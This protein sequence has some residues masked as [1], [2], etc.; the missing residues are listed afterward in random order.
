MDGQYGDTFRVRCGPVARATDFRLG[1]TGFEYC[2][3]MSNPDK[4]IYA[5]FS[6]SFGCMNDYLSVDIYVQI[7]FAH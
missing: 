5:T 6:M 3:E 2:G 7:V 1:E 4:F